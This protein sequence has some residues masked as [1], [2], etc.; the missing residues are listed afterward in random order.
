MWRI[1]FL[2]VEVLERKRS[3]DLCADW[4]GLAIDRSRYNRPATHGSNPAHGEGGAINCSYQKR[5]GFRPTNHGR[6]VP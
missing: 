4:V 1:T 2:E 6:S 3:V 5:R